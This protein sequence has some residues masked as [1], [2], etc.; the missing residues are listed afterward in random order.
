MASEFLRRGIG[1]LLLFYWVAVCAEA[2]GGTLRV[3]VTDA[4]SRPIANATVTVTATVKGSDPAISDKTDAEGVR[5]FAGLAPGRYTIEV[6]A[7]G[8]ARRAENAVI[9]NE[10]QRID[11]SLDVAAVV[12]ALTV[13]AEVSPETRGVAG[14]TAVVLERDLEESRAST[15]KD[16]LAFVP[17]VVVQ[18]RFGADESQISIRGSGLRNNFHLRGVNLLVNGIPYQDADG[19]SDFESLELF[20]TERIQ[21]W[22]GANALQY[23]GSSMG[24]AM[25]LVTYDGATADPLMLRVEAGAFG[26]FKAQIATGGANERLGWFGSVSRSTY[27]G[28][29]DYSE[30]ERT[31]LFGNLDWRVRPTTT[32]RFDAMYADVSEHL[33]GAL[34]QSE[35]DGDPDAADPTNRANRWGRFFDY[36]R[37]AAQMLHSIDAK[38]EIGAYVFAQRRSMVHPIFQILDQ[39]ADNGGA[40][41]NYRRRDL[42]GGRENRFVAG[43]TY[44][45]GANDEQ[46]FANVLGER[47]ALAAGFE[48]GAT[49]WALYAE[50]QLELTP[51]FT[52]T[53]GGRIDAA[54]RTFD[55]RFFGD[56]DRSA[57]RTF[58][59]VSPR[60]GVLWEARPGSQLFA[61][62]SR[63]YEP[64]LLLELTSFG[65]PGFLDLDA[66]ST[67]Q[68]ELG[69]RGARG[70]MQWDVAVYQA[71]MRNEIINLNVRPFPGAPFTVPSYRGAGRTRHRG[72][73]AG[74]SVTIGRNVFGTGDSMHLRGAYT[75]SDFRFVDDPAYGDNDL[76]GAAPH[77]LRAELRYERERWWIAPNVDASP[78]SYFTDSANTVKNDAYLVLNLR[79]GV[80]FGGAEFFAELA[81]VT[82]ELYSASVQVDSATGR[83]FEPAAPRNL[84]FGVRWSR[85]HSTERR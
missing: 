8:F 14:G 67:W 10:E 59:S 20:A 6:S 26:L 58:R 65:A 24:G 68:Y 40:E 53:A 74:A 54:R 28:Y 79:A 48:A 70:P 42:L 66:Q 39:E 64:P 50:N 11:I 21:V 34:T 13:V 46:R 29:R 55:D 9:G 27:D 77:L 7:P 35:L 81:N 76:P 63:S 25:N 56:G 30:Q 75:W 72:L 51:S 15:L 3:R 69:A 78:S 44:L 60:A 38:Q 47:G 73:E 31:R 84:A 1:V 19:F 18:P 85:R 17:G 43:V 36:T 62:V 32:I 57:E 82:D 49:T 45:D 2:R 4:S 22:K 41:V 71:D 61:N 37:L 33:P 5:V 23:G 16:V 80:R 52:L 83:I 12:S